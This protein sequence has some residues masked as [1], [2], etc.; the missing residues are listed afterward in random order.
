M[1]PE[2]QQEANWDLALTAL[3]ILEAP[4][5]RAG[6]W[7]SKPRHLPVLRSART[8]CGRRAGERRSASRA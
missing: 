8:F 6:S 5:F 2:F 7:R 1:K 4:N 3:P